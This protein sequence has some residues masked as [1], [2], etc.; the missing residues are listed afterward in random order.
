MLSH[1]KIIAKQPAASKMQSVL[2]YICT[3][4]SCSQF[5]QGAHNKNEKQTLIC[6]HILCDVRWVKWLIRGVATKLEKN[7]V[8]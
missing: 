6:E 7:H 8:S 4:M 3:I 1:E 5:T 2:R